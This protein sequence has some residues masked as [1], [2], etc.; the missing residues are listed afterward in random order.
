MLTK[1]LVA[2]DGR[3][4]SSWLLEQAGARPIA[5][6]GGPGHALEAVEH[7]AALTIAGAD[8]RFCERLRSV[9]NAAG[10]ESETSSDI[11]GVQLAGVAKNAAAL[12]AGVGDRRPA[13]T[14]PAARPAA[15]TPSA[16]TWRAAAARSSESFAGVAGA[17]DLVA[18]VLASSGRNRRAGELL[19]Q[20]V[21]AE[22][23]R[24]RARPG[25]GGDRHAAGAQRRGRPGRRARSGDRAA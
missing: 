11:V 20:G 13:P 23:D 14:P 21:D 25:P 22:R 5:C 3:L 7:G 6:L 4:P 16:T 10:I 12:A 19:A 24:R 8:R 15:S 9:F 2:P 18:T 17:G 1:G